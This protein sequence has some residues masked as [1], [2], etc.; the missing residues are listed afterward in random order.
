MMTVSKLV[1]LAG[2]LGLSMAASAALADTYSYDA[3]GRLISVT[4]ADGSSITYAY[5]SA[6]NRA[7]LT[8]TAAP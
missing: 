8:Q 6:G 3:L 5:D 4:F 1:I 2:A 7:T